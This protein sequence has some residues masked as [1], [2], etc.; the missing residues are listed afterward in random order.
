MHR[1]IYLTTDGQRECIFCW[2]ESY[3]SFFTCVAQLE[4]QYLY[5]LSHRDWPA[6]QL[7]IHEQVI[8]LSVSSDLWPQLKTLTATFIM[9][10]EL[11]SQTSVWKKEWIQIWSF[12][13]ITFEKS[14]CY[15]IP[16]KSLKEIE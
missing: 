10:G 1:I 3:L 5:F 4:N 2:Q 12:Q 6:G 11:R 14:I 7:N 9:G 16:K 15:V 13:G 8:F